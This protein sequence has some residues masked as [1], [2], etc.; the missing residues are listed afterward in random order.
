M[1]ASL[2]PFLLHQEPPKS[3]ALSQI[4]TSGPRPQSNPIPDKFFNLMVLPRDVTKDRLV[5]VMKQFSVTLAVRCSF[6][7]I[8][9]EDLTEASFD[10]GEKVAKI[11]TWELIKIIVQMSRN[12]S[13]EMSPKY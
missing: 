4:S 7:Y 12:N 3:Q 13:G 2:I 10:S 11:K 5:D 8:V 9:S 6:Y 1:I